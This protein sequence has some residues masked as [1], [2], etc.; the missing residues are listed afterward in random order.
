ML[1][2][3]SKKQ[4]NK[5]WRK[6]F[7]NVFDHS[8]HL[9]HVTIWIRWPFERTF[10]LNVSFLFKIFNTSRQNLQL[11]HFPIW[12]P[13]GAWPCCKMWQYSHV[14][15]K[16]YSFSSIVM[17]S[18][19]KLFKSFNLSGIGQRSNKDLDLWDPCIFKRHLRHEYLSTLSSLTFNSFNKIYSLSM[20]HAN[21]FK[22]LF[23]TLMEY[24]K[25][26]VSGSHGQSSH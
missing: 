4:A 16:I 3:F 13:K 7:L 14:V 24:I 2:E 17:F 1:Y 26:A 6:R 25:Y 9:N 8:S 5:L 19:E 18:L 11:K 12:E 21:L 22:L 15:Y 10:L 20:W 23:S